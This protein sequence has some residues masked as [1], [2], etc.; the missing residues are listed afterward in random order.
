M[1]VA[2]TRCLEA[3]SCGVGAE[4]RIGSHLG[5]SPST[6]LFQ[7]FLAQAQGQTQGVQQGESALGC[8]VILGQPFLL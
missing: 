4:W 1:V 3:G 7:M 8:P 5:L 2:Q 6:H